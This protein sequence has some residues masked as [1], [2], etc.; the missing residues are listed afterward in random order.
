MVRATSEFGT[1]IKRL[2]K[3][4]YPCESKGISQSILIY[5]SVSELSFSQSSSNMAKSS[6]SNLQSPLRSPGNGS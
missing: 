3:L 6:S 5:G 4:K 1:H 2:G